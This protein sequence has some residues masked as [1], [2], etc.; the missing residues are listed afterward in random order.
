M[1]SLEELI[2]K[3][4]QTM[5]SIERALANFK[6]LGQSKMTAATTQ[7][8]MA[9]LKEAFLQCQDLHAK[10]AANADP[11]T[12]TSASYF[13]EDQF[14][15]CEERYQ[16][17]QDFMAETLYKV[18][19]S[20]DNSAPNGSF[21][22]SM[23]SRPPATHL[24]RIHLPTFEGA[25]EEWESFRDRF[26]SMVINNDTLSNVDRLHFL[27]SSLKG[28]ASRAVS[29]LPV[30]E[31]NFEV[32]WQI[33]TSR[34]DNKRR[35]VSTH[36]N[37]LFSL[38]SVSSETPS[39]L[40]SLRDNIN[41][42]IQMLRNLQRPTEAWSDIIVFLG[43]QKLDRASRKAWEFNL[44]D[45]TEFPTYEEFDTF[46]EKRIRALEALPT[47]KRE[48]PNESDKVK[49]L[50]SKPLSI[51][52]TTTYKILC[53]VCK[54]NHLLYQCPTFLAKTPSE[55]YNILKQQKRCVNCF[56]VKH[57]AV[58]CTST[59]H[60]KECQQ[61]HHT[62]L[63]FRTSNEARATPQGTSSNTSEE[64]V[65]I[66]SN[67]AFKSPIHTRILLSTARVRVHSLA[68]R[69]V[70]ARAL[71]DQGSAAT[72]ISEHLA[73]SLRLERV[74]RTTQI[75]GIGEI[76]SVAR[77]VADILITPATKNEPAYSTTAIVMT[78]LTRYVP[79]RNN[80]IA[81]LSH[82]SGLKLADEDPM[83]SDP[84]DLII[85]ADIYGQLLLHE[86]RQGSACTPTAQHTTLG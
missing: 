45:S 69:C 53:A 65:E 33:I 35:L 1:S 70:I 37:T 11:R 5:R 42:S 76:Q 20:P 31:N 29:H 3:Q 79:S 28:D 12:K 43:S 38:P 66:S 25:F 74:R 72:L 86:V 84:I 30:T 71:L 55:R 63:H 6:K 24:P 8:R 14:S 16:E 75:T 50:K 10:I 80:S 32:A 82:L 54:Q 57:A 68:G 34:Y 18:S 9:M 41:I 21:S 83:S 73:Q 56:S 49:H 4:T 40:R 23:T 46:L 67:F 36:L 62:L 58:Q 22:N 15:I 19:P 61:K 64:G 78:A 59:H 81:T 60:C 51:N 47:S 17:A 52:S 77:H 2:Q 44:G 48:K 27:C 85:G 7:N 13:V 26:T 39:E